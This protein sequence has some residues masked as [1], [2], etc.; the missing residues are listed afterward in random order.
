M[1]THK[2]AFA[3]CQSRIKLDYAFCQA[4]WHQLPANLQAAIWATWNHGI[5]RDS[6]QH[7]VSVARAAGHLRSKRREAEATPNVDS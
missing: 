1:E 2:C 5:G 6:P 4:H 3:G 7:M